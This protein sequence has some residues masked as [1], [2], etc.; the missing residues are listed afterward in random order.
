MIGKLWS[1]FTK[2]RAVP[3][4]W[5]WYCTACDDADFGHDAEG[6]LNKANGECPL[7]RQTCPLDLREKL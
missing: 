1:F 3:K 7:G 5:E 2:K 4:N 6:R